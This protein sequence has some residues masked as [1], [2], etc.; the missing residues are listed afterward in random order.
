MTNVSIRIV[1]T[2]LFGMLA[3]TCFAPVATSQDNFDGAVWAFKMSKKQEPKKIIGGR[4]R[5]SNHVLFQKFDPSD[6]QFS[7][8]VGKNHPNGQKT[9]FDVDDFRVFT[10]P[11]KRLILIKG[12][13]RLS[14]DKIG[15]WS[16]IF[17]DGRGSN[18]TFKASRIKE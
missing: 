4:F 1:A 7:K 14:M 3:A 5:V 18:W 12:T 10:E 2:F 17:T 11:K 9:R 6:A 13:G 15:E 16:G 8:R